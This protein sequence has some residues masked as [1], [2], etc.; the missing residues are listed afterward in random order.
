[1]AKKQKKVE[2]LKATK[3]VDSVKSTLLDECQG[4]FTDSDN[5]MKPLKV[6]WPDKEAMLLGRN[7]DGISQN[8]KSQINDPRL[9]T[10]VFE[11]GA[12]VMSRPPAGRAYAESQ[13]DIGKNMFMNLLLPHFQKKDN[14]QYS[15][16]LKLRFTDIYSH[17]YGS[18]F[19]LVP[20]RVNPKTGFMGPGYNVLRMRDCFP[21]PGI[22]NYTEWDYFIHRTW[23]STQWL[24]NQDPEYW[25]MA[26]IDL[27]IAE[28]KD[29]KSGGDTRS[30]EQGTEAVSYVEDQ[31]FPNAHVG[32]SV[33]PQVELRTE[34]RVD[35]WITWTPQHPNSKTG[36]PHILRMVN[37]P[38][39]GGMLPIVVKHSFPLLDSPIGLGEFERG[40]TLQK[41]L[42]SLWNLYMDGVK[43]SI[44]PPMAVDPN[45]VVP[46]SI[47]WGSNRWYMNTPGRDVQPINLSPQGLQTF[48]STYDFILGAIYNQSGTT[49]VAD[50]NS[51]GGTSMGKTPEA[52]RFVAERESAR[53]EWDRFMMEDTIQQIYDRWMPLITHNL[54]GDVMLRMFG[55]EAQNIA[56]RYNDIDELLKKKIKPSKSGES[57]RIRIG[58]KDLGGPN[59]NYDWVIVP[60]STM[61][62]SA[63]AQGEAVT[64]VL[65][66][67]IENG[68]KFE[69]GLNKQGKT[70]DTG[71]LF[72][73]W[74]EAR[75]LQRIDKIVVDLPKTT[76]AVTTDN[77]T[78]G[79]DGKPIVAPG[80]ETLPAAPVNN[81]VATPPVEAAPVTPTEAAAT[82]VPALPQF[83]DPQ[84]AEHVQQLFGGMNG[85]PAVAA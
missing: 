8:T 40:Q 55:E 77:V 6:E 24:K 21:Q 28:L 10:I 15:H 32:D 7:L 71:E 76:D 80:G 4:H 44:F 3:E 68:D 85:M 38:Y 25:D 61:K 74:L 35:K 36:R 60:G 41:G 70:L 82:E 73:Q 63:D 22:S 29:S 51:G 2:D 81:G 17:V 78:V 62:D 13:D 67:V 58:G 47:K 75:K 72:T 42:N 48:S 84:L 11:R 69:A 37:D 20:W 43:K 53:D 59:E 30:T 50:G 46:S 27:L 31:R 45:N 16:L 14:D 54:D 64:D 56:K 12:R 79:P 57:V 19:G 83:K 66:A 34:Y 23:V 9:S 39:V 33:F 52:V 5:Y 65:K 49:S 26:E 1:M 18:T